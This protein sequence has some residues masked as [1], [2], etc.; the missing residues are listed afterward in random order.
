MPLF[1]K[2]ESEC[3]T[4]LDKW[5]YLV[6][7]MEKLKEIPW[8]AQDEVLAELEKVSNIAALSSEERHLYEINR[9]VYRDNLAVLEASYQDG[10]ESGFNEGHES[11]VDEA[12]QKIALS[13]IRQGFADEMIAE[14]TSLSHDEI[15]KLRECQV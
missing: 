13:L 2:T 1:N 7:N 9:R 3:V 5:T 10:H 14:T 12:T 8:K 4:N 6:K 11:G 15:Q